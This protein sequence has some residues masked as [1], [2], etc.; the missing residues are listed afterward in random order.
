MEAVVHLEESI[1]IRLASTYA[2]D[3][4]KA[5]TYNSLGVA[6]ELNSELNRAYAAYSEALRLA[7]GNTLVLYNLAETR[8]KQGIVRQERGRLAE[9]VAFYSVG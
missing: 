2:T 4:Q 7:P 9:A 3:M 5:T 6:Y 1:R 8:V